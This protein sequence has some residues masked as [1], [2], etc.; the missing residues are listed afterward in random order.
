MPHKKGFIIIVK[1]IV[2]KNI[3]SEFILNKPDLYQTHVILID[4]RLSDS[5]F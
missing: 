2:T 4:F 5:R 3:K 1:N